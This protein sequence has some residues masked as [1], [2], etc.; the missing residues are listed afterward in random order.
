MSKISVAK[1]PLPFLFCF[2]R[3]SILSV[4]IIWTPK[5]LSRGHRARSSCS[6]FG[7]FPDRN[8]QKTH[9]FLIDRC[10]HK[11]RDCTNTK[12][13]FVPP[14][15]L[16]LTRLRIYGPITKPFPQPPMLHR[17][18]ARLLPSHSF[19]DIHPFLPDRT[20]SDIAAQSPSQCTPLASLV[21]G[22][23]K[24][25]SLGAISRGFIDRASKGGR[26]V[27]NIRKG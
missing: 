11:L 12:H 9:S 13:T 27:R 8:Y 18:F 25:Q 4:C 10:I 21:L 23:E 26:T 20:P 24:K 7:F 6:C 22:Q 3:E 14:L 17:C 2:F 16:P 15:S 19:P 1:R 5:A